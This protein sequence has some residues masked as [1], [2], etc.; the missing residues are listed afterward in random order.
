MARNDTTDNAMIGDPEEMLYF[1]YYMKQLIN[2]LDRSRTEALQGIDKMGQ[3]FK[4]EVFTTFEEEFHKFGQYIDEINEYFE[5][6]SKY[7]MELTGILED[8]LKSKGTGLGGIRI[9]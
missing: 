2:E 8:H 7:Y 1:S 4:D 5:K 9:N 6:S 3:G